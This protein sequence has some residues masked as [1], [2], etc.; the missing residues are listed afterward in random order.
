M[1]QQTPRI[2]IAIPVACSFGVIAFVVSLLVGVSVGNP[3][4]AVLAR[5]LWVMLVAWPIGLAAGF[6]LERLFR[7][8]VDAE[9]A[10]MSQVGVRAG[11]SD[12][13]VE[14]IDEPDLESEGLVG[15][16]DAASA[17]A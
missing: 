16:G 4:G 5:S 14:I 15:D 3:A 9:T 2:S 7:E 6:V 8:Q 12:D 13:D 10:Q 17:A 1:V 11:E